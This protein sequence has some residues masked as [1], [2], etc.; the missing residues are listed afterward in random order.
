MKNK[1]L[2]LIIV[3]AGFLLLTPPIIGANDS[4]QGQENENEQMNQMELREQK[5]SEIEAYKAQLREQKVKQLEEREAERYQY[6]LMLQEQK[7]ERERNR[8]TV[9]TQAEESREE[10]IAQI[11]E[12]RAEKLVEFTNKLE[13]KVLRYYERLNQISEKL[14]VKI[15]GYEE[16][17]INLELAKVKLTDADLLLEEAYSNAMALVDTVR[18]SD[19]STQEGFG[20]VISMVKEMK[21]PFR[22]VL[23]LYKE[24]VQEIREAV[25]NSKLNEE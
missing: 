10:R 9:K 16:D 15:V 1:K 17:D 18:S 8:E 6:E 25:N 23:Q 13:E 7:K 3:F 14:H 12:N 20:K 24:V 11:T 22:E 19:V 21:N 5:A 2:F 4:S